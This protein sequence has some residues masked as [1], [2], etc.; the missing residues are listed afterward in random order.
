MPSTFSLRRLWVLGIS[1]TG[2]LA[3]PMGDVA[4][5]KRAI[6][7][8]TFDDLAFYFKY[9]SSAYYESS[10]ASPNGNTLVL[11]INQPV[12]NTQGYIARDDNR[13]EIVVALRGSTNIPDFLT[14]ASIVLVPFVSPGIVRPPLELVHVGF[15]TAWNSI[16]KQV[17]SAIQTEL[18]AYPD[19]NLVTSGHS[20]GGA[21]SSLAAITLHQNFPEKANGIRMFTYGQPRTFNGA[22]AKFVNDKFGFRAFRAVHTDDGVPSIPPKSITGVGYRHH[23]VEYWN[24]DM[25]LRHLRQPDNA[26]L[27]GRIQH[28][29]I[30]YARP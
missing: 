27:V 4:H 23:G 20:L 11:Q 6:D 21:L 28:V 19:Y 24:F 14:D 16:A 15:L 10:C 29:Q 17:I 3:M 12:T 8:A 2:V 26:T 7:Q 1:L 22:A 5:Q 30:L 9:A 25:T 18:A 13:R